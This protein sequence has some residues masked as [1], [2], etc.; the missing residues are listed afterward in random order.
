MTI[1]CI[2][3]LVLTLV[4]RPKKAAEI[5][6]ILCV[7]VLLLTVVGCSH[8]NSNFAWHRPALY[9]NDS[10]APADLNRQLYLADLNRQQSSIPMVNGG[11]GYSYTLLN[12]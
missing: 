4:G 9:Y 6:T 2:L 1:L 7:S 12:W 11:L 3:L 10:K 8:S 5:M